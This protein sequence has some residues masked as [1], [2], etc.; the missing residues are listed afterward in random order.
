MYWLLMLSRCSLVEVVS[1]VI[2][3]LMIVMLSMCMLFVLCDGI[4]DGVGRL[5]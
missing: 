1:L 4:Y 2:L 5:S 3:L